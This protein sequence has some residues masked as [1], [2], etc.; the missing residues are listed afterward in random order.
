MEGPG[1]IP[2]RG[3]T[4]LCSQMLNLS[5]DRVLK[6]KFLFYFYNHQE[7]ARVAQSVER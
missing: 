4:L 7:A 5:K 6:N 1:S 3:V 2:G